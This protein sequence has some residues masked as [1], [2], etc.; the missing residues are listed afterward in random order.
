MSSSSLAVSSPDNTGAL[1]VECLG[2]GMGGVVADE[3]DCWD[4]SEGERKTH[5]EKCENSDSSIA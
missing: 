2:G 3:Y 1:C 5:R 4:L